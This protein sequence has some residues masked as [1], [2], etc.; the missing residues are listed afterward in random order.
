MIR[1]KRKHIVY[2]LIIIDQT[3]CKCCNVKSF[4][5]IYSN[6]INKKETIERSNISDIHCIYIII[7][8]S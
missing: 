5:M 1:M 8:I 7:I 4:E 6:N 3:I 2:Y